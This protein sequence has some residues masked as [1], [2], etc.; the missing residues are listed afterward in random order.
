MGQ[1]ENSERRRALG[2]CVALVEF[3]RQLREIVRRTSAEPVRRTCQAGDDN[4]R[5]FHL[6]FPS[7]DISLNRS[8]SAYHDSV[9]R[10]HGQCWR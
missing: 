6:E 1:A 9:P 8:F 10:G 2:N 7:A 3:A 5:R 4:D